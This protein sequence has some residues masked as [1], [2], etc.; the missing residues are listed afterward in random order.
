MKRKSCGRS[1]VDETTRSSFQVTHFS[2]RPFRPLLGLL[3]AMS[4]SVPATAGVAPFPPAF[5][6]QEIETDGA[7]IHVRVGGSGPGVV[8]LH[9]FGDTGDMWAPLAAELVRDHTI[10]VPDLR[11]MGLSSLPEAGYDKKTQAG[12]IGASWTR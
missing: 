3:F 12:D 10:V 9:G 6:T 5:H 1:S 8:L 4:F 2:A 7:T 11:G